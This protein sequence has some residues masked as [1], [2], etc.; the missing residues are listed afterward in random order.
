MAQQ[1]LQLTIARV[2]EPV[3]DGSVISVT[4]PGAAGEMTL[5]AHHTAIIS[6]LRSG[7]IRVRR[8]DDSVQE[9][10]IESGT[11]EL[12]KNHAMILI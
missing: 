1:L 7:L 12:S 11:L 6:P 8:E 9:F 5:L 3:F 2:D 10:L 4:V